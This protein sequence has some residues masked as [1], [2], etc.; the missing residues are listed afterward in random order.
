[1]PTLRKGKKLDMSDFFKNFNYDKY[2]LYVKLHPE[3][4]DDTIDKRINVINKYTG[5]QI[6]SVADYVIT[7]YS[8]IMFEA[9]LC[10][11]KVF[12]YIPDIDEYKKNPGLN[13]DV[14]K[15]FK[16]VSS[17]AKEVVK[18]LDEDYD[19]DLLKAF[20]NKYVGN[21]DGKC[22]ERIRDFILKKIN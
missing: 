2:N 14:S 6:I 20:C 21:F 1:M 12:L 5:E 7:D 22:V 4:Q 10:G 3:Y 9:G 11:K 19:M 17:D 16:Y 13:V 18:M 15:D 8:N